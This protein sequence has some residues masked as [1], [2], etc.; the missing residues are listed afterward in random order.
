[1]GGTELKKRFN[2]KK[3]KGR[4]EEGTNHEGTKVKR[5][6]SKP[7]VCFVPSW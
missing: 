1:M 4:K 2:H 7:F 3:R 5:I 6:M